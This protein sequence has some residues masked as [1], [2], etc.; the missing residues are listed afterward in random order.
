MK[1]EELSLMG[2]YVS[3]ISFL[4]HLDNLRSLD[5]SFT[6]VDNVGPLLRCKNLRK[7]DISDTHIKDITPLKNL[8]N[9]ET[10]K[11]WN[12]WLDRS[13]VDELKKSLPDLNVVD[14]Q[15]DLYEKDSIDRVVPKLRVRLN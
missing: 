8:P 5:I 2:Q 7:L 15:W 9:L 1:I 11:M 4:T 3:D 14:Y 10:L 6:Y 12:L 13:Q